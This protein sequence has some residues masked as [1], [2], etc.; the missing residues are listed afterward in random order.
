MRT[1]NQCFEDYENALLARML[2]M[3]EH[4]ND[5]ERHKGFAERTKEA[6]KHLASCIEDAQSWHT[7]PQYQLKTEGLP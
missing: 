4:P 7:H 5:K 1:L 3:A 6:R 2:A